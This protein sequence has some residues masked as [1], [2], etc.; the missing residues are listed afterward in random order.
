MTALLRYHSAL[1]LR[2]QRWLAPLLLYAAL[3]AVGVR[4]GDPVLG[5]L[6]IA[7][8][9]LVPVSAWTV[10]IFLTQEPAAA[11]AV[12]AAAAGRSRAHL[13]ALLAGAGWAVL[14]GA[15]AA[16]A[17]TATG[18][19][20]GTSGP[21]ALLAGLLAT[22]ACALTGGA[23]G[24]LAARPFVRAP[25]WS[26]AALLL[27][28]LAALVTTGSPAKHAVTAL[29]ADG[30]GARPPWAAC[31]AALL[32]AAVTATASRRAGARLE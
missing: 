24:A 5:S 8:A 28:S 13:A 4:P 30:G 1:F 19:L 10:R 9:G 26:V 21:A 31:A 15:A 2:S 11:R 7:A 12:V 27:G 6:G 14:A 32:L 23:V 3:V 16:C 20:A 18:G 17:V 25:G 22:T 29:V